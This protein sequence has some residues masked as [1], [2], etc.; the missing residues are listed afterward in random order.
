MSNQDNKS[1]SQGMKRAGRGGGRDRR[2]R[3]GPSN[4][5][6]PKSSSKSL[7]SDEAVPMLK[8]GPYN[9]F[10]V[11]K[12]RLKTA[13]ME[14]YGDLARLIELE[15]YWEPEAVDKD[16]D[17]P[18][19]GTDEFV[20]A[21]LIHAIKERATVIAKMRANRA[22]MFAYILSKLSKESIDELKRHQD[23]A[24]IDEKVD[25]LLLWKAIKELHMVATSSKVTQV[26]KR[27]AREEYQSCKQGAFESLVD[28]K[29]R[30]D[31]RYDA[32]KDQGNVELSEEDV[33][34]DFLESLDRARYSEFI[35]ETIND[36]AKGVMVPPKD[37]NQIY[38]LA[39][40]RLVVKKG[41]GHLNV[42]ASYATVEASRPLQGKKGKGK[43]GG[44]NKGGK[45]LSSGASDKDKTDSSDNKNKLSK[46]EKQKKRLENVECFNC[47]KKGHF[48]RDC[49][50]GDEDASDADDLVGVT[51]YDGECLSTS[52]GNGDA[53]KYYEV[54]L[55]SGSQINIVHP[56]FL[57]DVREGHGGCKGLFG[58]KTRLTKVGMLEGFFECLCSDDTRVS[59]LSQADVEDAYEVTYE[60]GHSY[61][62]HMPGKDVEF[63][64][65][66]KLYVADFSEWLDPEYEECYAMLSLMTAEERE[67][68]YTRKEVRRARH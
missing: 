60:P 41:S 42:G 12:E 54:I 4:K 65:R 55:D 66:N 14:K 40:T 24:E 25:P 57:R 45:L 3:S 26:V 6:G 39:N 34:M 36:I 1:D 20:K 22:S 49:P 9:N 17:Y 29:A 21:A 5:G 33:A 11:F 37:V 23:Y 50:E 19:A 59:V 16:K 53:V 51:Q 43:K 27:K 46:E 18:T 58:S 35:V 61:T 32:Y 13:C 63:V 2:G 38:V 44:N 31:S 56:R 62:V 10:I 7:N 68:M 15:I 28:F 67:H 8:Y 47:G 64:R 30:F 48:A 52:N